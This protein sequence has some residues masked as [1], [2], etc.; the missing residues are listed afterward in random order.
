MNR[1]TF[2]VFVAM[3]IVALLL[4]SGGGDATVG[5]LVSV[6]IVEETSERPLLPA[7]QL[8]I[9]NSAELREWAKTHCDKGPDGAPEF[10]VLDKDADASRMSAKWRER[11]ERSRTMPTPNIAVSDGRR[12]AEGDLPLTLNEVKAVLR[13]YAGD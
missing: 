10:R 9:L 2:V 11:F 1:K 12:G 8:A 3:I 6:L 13:R 7:S 4:P 5:G